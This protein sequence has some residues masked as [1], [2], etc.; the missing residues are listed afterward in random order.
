MPYLVTVRAFIDE[1]FEQAALPDFS[2]AHLLIA[3]PADNAIQN[4]CAPINIIKV[5][6]KINST[7]PAEI[8]KSYLSSHSPKAIHKVPV[9]MVRIPAKNMIDS[10]SIQ[11]I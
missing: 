4:G 8:T 1:L 11:I 2:K 9:Y 5:N 3:A 6:E 10:N 7:N